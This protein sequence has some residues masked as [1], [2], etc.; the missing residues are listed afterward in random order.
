MDA[1]N[2]KRSGKPVHGDVQAPQKPPSREVGYCWGGACRGS[3]Q[4]HAVLRH[5][6]RGEGRRRAPLSAWQDADWQA[7]WPVTAVRSRV[8]P[9]EDLWIGGYILKVTWLLVMGNLRIS[10]FYKNL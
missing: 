5:V 7:D 6:D 10:V 2:A 4:V 9:Q 1:L 8:L 3:C